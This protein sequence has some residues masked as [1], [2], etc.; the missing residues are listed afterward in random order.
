MKKA[1]IFP[2]QGTQTIGMAKEFYDNFE[3]A[4]SVFEEVNE[5]LKKDLSKI[6]FEGPGDVLNSTEN[7]QPAIM[8]ASMAILRVLQKETG[9]D[10]TEQ[11]SFVAGH[12]LGEYTALCASEAISLSDT[13]SLLKIR[14]EAFYNVGKESKGA[15]LV[16]TGAAI[17]DINEL[18]KQVTAD[19]SICQI[20]NDNTIGQFVI[21]GD[22]KC[23]DKA[24]ELAND[25]P[26]RRSVKLAVSGAFHS[27]L[28]Q[29]ACLT[30]EEALKN[31]QINKPLVPVISNYTAQL[32]DLASI[33]NN[34]VLQ[35]TNTV[36][37]RETMIYLAE[38]GC[39]EF[40]EIGVSRILKNM[41]AKAE[42]NVKA[43]NINSI[44]AM[45][46]FIEEQC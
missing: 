6:M 25:M 24:A 36:R 34:L 13:A 26:I 4:R 8:C 9:C 31:I 29:S 18:I 44:E 45:K 11:C 22:A 14:G 35:I 30:M 37:W 3:V 12:S 38:Q 39:E 2:G 27:K 43:V 23:I 41:A 1:F 40:V 5:V 15:M 19:G 46:Q 28:M 17:E 20:A 10:I 42:L 21:S 16:L 33:K 7:T 32:E